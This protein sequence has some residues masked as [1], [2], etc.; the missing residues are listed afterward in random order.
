MRLETWRLEELKVF[1]SLRLPI[2]DA[3]EA[4][5]EVLVK[6]AGETEFAWT[7]LIQTKLFAELLIELF[8]EILIEIFKVKVSLVVYYL[9]F[10]VS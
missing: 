9:G 4:A 3:A 6:L 1:N 10:S 8:I 7:E 5:A 2:E